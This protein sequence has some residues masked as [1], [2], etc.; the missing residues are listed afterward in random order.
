MAGLVKK[1]MDQ[2]NPPKKKH[3]FM[4]GLK[5]WALSPGGV[6]TILITIALV[7]FIEYKTSGKKA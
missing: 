6:A 4:D 3:S 7:A 1:A 5:D 2:I